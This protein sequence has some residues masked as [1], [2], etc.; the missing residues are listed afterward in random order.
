MKAKAVSVSRDNRGLPA[1]TQPALPHVVELT[2]QTTQKRKTDT[3]KDYI[4]RTHAIVEPQMTRTS[5]RLNNKPDLAARVEGHQPQANAEVDPK[6]PTSLADISSR[7]SQPYASAA[8]SR[9]VLYI[10][11]DVH[12]DSI[13]ISLAPSDSTEVRR[14]GIIGGTHDDVLKLL[15]KLQAAHPGTDLRACYEAGPR[16]YPL[17]RFIRAHGHT[18]IIVAP[19]KIPRKP[20]DRVKTDRRDADQLARLYRAGELTAIYVLDARDESVRD[21][22]RGRYQIGRQQHR[23]RQQLKMF[24]LRHNIRY[25]GKTAWSPAHLRYLATVK[26][27]FAEQQFVF[28]EMLDVITEAG[29]RLERYEA[30]LPGVVAGWR[31]EPVVR[32]LMSLRGVAL[33]NAAT[34]VAELGDLERFTAAN[35]LMSYLGLVPSEDT[36][37]DDR[38]QGGITKMGNGIARRAIIEAAWHYR[39]PARITPTL[40]VRQEGLPKIV[41]QAAWNAQTRLH[42]RFKH[43]TGVRHKKSQVAAAALGR[44]LAGFV[45]AIGRMVKPRALIPDNRP[46]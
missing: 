21:L 10:G 5:Q 7:G 17:C 44:E 3:M 16:G 20:G 38:Q 25:M 36:T 14:Y 30:Q 12:N 45:W 41:T 18:C 32:A 46:V 24:L 19:S 15:N 4:L 2:S 34:L 28:Q 31:W 22:L 1:V 27:P 33:L 26:M 43:L 23:A 40:Q 37:G 29:K 9:P 11:M 35:Q 6:A 13:A 42:R 39:L 8:T